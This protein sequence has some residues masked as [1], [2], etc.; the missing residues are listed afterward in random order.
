MNNISII[1][2]F[3][4]IRSRYDSFA[5]RVISLE[6]INIDNSESKYNLIVIVVEKNNEE[7]SDLLLIIEE[8][9]SKKVEDL[10]I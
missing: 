1:V 5:K 9:K 6:N 7:N 8:K 10:N 4:I 3:I 2:V